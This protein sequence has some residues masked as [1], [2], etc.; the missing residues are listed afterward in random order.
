MAPLYTAFGRTSSTPLPPRTTTAPR[1][2]CV[3]RRGA[4]E[5]AELI[6]ADAGLALELADALDA[7]P[8][9][10]EI[11]AETDEALSLTGKDV[12]TPIIHFEPPTGVAFF[13]PVIS[14]LPAED[15][16]AV[17]W[18][19]VNRH[20]PRDHPFAG[21]NGS[22]R[23]EQGGPLG[24]SHYSGLIQS[25]CAVWPPCSRSQTIGKNPYRP[26][27]LAVKT[28]SVVCSSSGSV[29]SVFSMTITWPVVWC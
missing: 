8:W 25:V 23:R 10:A 29:G 17:S 2:R 9:N 16:A 7:E 4:R 3:K 5:R 19:H 14:R 20:A 11:R 22:E 13:G 18:D 15:S 24:L 12:G 26:W 6:L 1:A 27:S 21:R 28:M